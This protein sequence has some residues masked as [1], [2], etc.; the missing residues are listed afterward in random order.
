MEKLWTPGHIGLMETKNRTV[1][2]ATN[3]HL[4]TRQGE[5]TQAWMDV[6]LELARGGVGVI[7]TG[8]F[9]M[10][11]TQRADEGQPVLVENMESG[12]L[13]HSCEILRETARRVMNTQPNWWFSS[14]TPAPRHWSL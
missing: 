3:E 10:D 7:I 14:A 4:A 2:S 5:L 11:A 13:D 1:R 6:N 8:Q 12:M 9:A